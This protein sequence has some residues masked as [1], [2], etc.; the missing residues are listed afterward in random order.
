VRVSRAALMAGACATAIVFTG[1]GSAAAGAHEVPASA[2]GWGKAIE[3]PGTAKLNVG[4]SAITESVSCPSAGN[5]AAAG[6]YTDGTHHVLPFVVSERNGRWRRAI[7]VP[8]FATLGAGAAQ[9]YADVHSVSCASAGNCAAGGSYTDSHGAMQAFV[10]SERNGRWR[11][12]IEVPGT[13]TPPLA[14]GGAEVDAI[15]CPVAGDCEAAGT[16]FARGTVN[17]QAFV[18][19]QRGGRWGSAIE[20]PGVAQ[21]GAYAGSGASSLSCP[22]AGNCA[23]GGLTGSAVTGTGIPFVVREHSGT[24][25]NAVE[26]RGTSAD[27][28]VSALSC[29]RAG[30]C[31]ASVGAPDS[32][33]GAFVVSQH[34]GRWG[35]AIEI[36]GI[37]ALNHGYDSVG[38]LSCPAVGYCTATGIYENTRAIAQVFVVNETRGRWGTAIEAPGTGALNA[39][40][41]QVSALSCASAGDCAAAGYYIDSLGHSQAFV[42]SEQHGHWGKAIELPGTGG[43]NVGGY[44]RVL[45]VSCAPTGKCVAAG[46][47]T[48]GSGHRQ[49]FVATGS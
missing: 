36:P 39:N 8:G 17:E 37:A 25:A 46:V 32:Y 18:V 22:S 29:P 15:S 42:V 45:S 38:S 12:A 31:A 19:S 21:L 27:S 47:Y 30:D 2:G 11:N 41:I 40:G 6:I 33:L 24:W 13:V 34:D 48:D 1:A 14:N 44:A 9:E 4:G 7:E 28:Q 49:A 20:V 5:C 16:Y 3:V 35:R 26:V 10:V 23:A 43:L